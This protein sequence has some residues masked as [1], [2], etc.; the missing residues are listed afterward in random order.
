MTH[1]LCDSRFYHCHQLLVPFPL[2]IGWKKKKR[3]ECIKDKAKERSKKTPSRN[4]LF[5]YHLDFQCM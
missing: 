4:L 2:I 3:I 5:S 1:H